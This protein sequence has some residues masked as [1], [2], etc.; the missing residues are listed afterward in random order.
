MEIKSCRRE[1]KS[2]MLAGHR[3]TVTRPSWRRQEPSILLRRSWPPSHVPSP[4]SIKEAC[5]LT[6]ARRLFPTLVHCLLG[7][8]VFWIKS[9]FLCPDNSSLHLLA[10]CEASSTSLHSVALPGNIFNQRQNRNPWIKSGKASQISLK[11]RPSPPSYYLLRWASI[12]FSPCLRALG[13]Q[14]NA[15][16]HVWSLPSFLILRAKPSKFHY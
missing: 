2:V 16:S 11:P 14:L 3:N 1:N 7:L 6:Q 10:C 9:P 13:T 8:L 4:F 5:I 12:I 15:Q